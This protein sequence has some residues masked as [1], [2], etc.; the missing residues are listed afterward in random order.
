M[1]YKIG[2]VG[3]GIVGSATA[4]GFRFNG[5]CKDEN[6]RIYDK[7]KEEV[8]ILDL[9]RRVQKNEKDIRSLMHNS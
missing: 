3:C 1:E 7:Y 4:N 6:I 5:F 9:Q 8:D 2:I